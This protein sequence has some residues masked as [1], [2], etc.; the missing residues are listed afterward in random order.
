MTPG[1]LGSAAI[2]L[3]LAQ[4][5]A[6]C[7]V[8]G[9]GMLCPRCKASLVPRPRA[10]LPRHPPTGFPRTVA[11]M[12]YEHVVR[13]LLVTHKEHA[14]LRL[15]H[16]LGLLLSVAVAARLD[17]PVRPVVLVPIPSRRRT[18]RSRGHDPVRRMAHA[19]AKA[20]AGEARVDPV[21]R[22]RRRVDDQSHLSAD[23]RRANLDGAFQ[24]ARPLAV[25]ADGMVVLVDDICSSGATLAAAATALRTVATTAPIVGAAVVASPRLRI[26]KA[27]RRREDVPMTRRRTGD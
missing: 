9:E 11:A 10:V 1:S 26:G 12:D 13:R 20:L 22:H 18:T 6:G 7:G 19:A 27:D 2:D 25:P 16:P 15:A 3:L 21:L 4:P 17:D 23:Q 14:A 24:A 5:C 8:S